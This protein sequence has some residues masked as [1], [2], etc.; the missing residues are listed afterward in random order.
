MTIAIPIAASRRM[1]AASVPV[2][3]SAAHSADAA[4]AMAFFDA[5][6]EIFAQGDVSGALYRVE[7]GC[8]RVYRL[9]AEG[10]R[11]ISAFH[12]PGEVFGFESDGTHF[13]FADAVGETGLRTV[14]RNC[15]IALGQDVVSHMLKDMC[16]A[17]R[18]LLLLARHD[19]TARIAA[20]L[21]DMVERQ[22]RVNEVELPMPRGDMADYLGLTIETVSRILSKLRQTG[23]IRMRTL[24]NFEIPRLQTLRDLSD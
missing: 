20:F 4:Q 16:M 7:F 9:L 6:D 21:L 8:V 18:H 15:G 17:R 3:T 22:G 2:G 11:Q 14:S 19:A 23:V 1:H 13:F 24:R 5:G 12:L 10:R